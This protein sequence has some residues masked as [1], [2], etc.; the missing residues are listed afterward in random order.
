MALWLSEEIIFLDTKVYLKEG[1][2]GTDLHVKPTDT[3][4]YVRKKAAMH[5][6]AK[7]LFLIAKCF[8]SEEFVQRNYIFRN[9]PVSLKNV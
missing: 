6:T 3:H 8:A 9:G 1:Q 4:Q 7:P 2:V 5:I